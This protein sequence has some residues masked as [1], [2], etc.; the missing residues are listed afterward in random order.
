LWSQH[1][2]HRLLITRL[3]L[4][5]DLHVF[6]GKNVSLFVE[7][8]LCQISA[9]AAVCYALERFTGFERFLKNTLEGLFGFCLFHLNQAENLT[10][11]F[12]VSFVLPFTLAT[13]ALLTIAFFERLRHPKPA[14]I[15]IGLT[16]LLAGLNLAGGLLLGPVAI[17]FA[18]F[19]RLPARCIV[20]VTTLFLVSSSAYLI[21]YKA[22]DPNHTVLDALP[23]GKELFVYLLTYLGASWTKLLP[24]KE[25]LI[26]FLSLVAF[27]YLVM[28]AVR[29]RSRTTSFE[30]FC[31]AECSLLIATAL[32]TGLGRLQ[33][34]VG[35]AYAGRY[36]TPAMLYWASLCAL[37]LIAVWRL[38]PSHFAQMQALVVLIL[39]WSAFTFVPLW[40]TTVRHADLLSSACYTVMHGNQD[41]RAAKLLYGSRQDV[42]P[43]A[44]YLRHLWH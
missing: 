15:A 30:W 2:E 44:A 16:P 28:Q 1:N 14:S 20:T 11:A 25:R 9:W 12:Q 31:A 6:G 7:T 36:Q 38:R 43:G 41:E 32:L 21:G 3:L 40:R 35:Q 24:H 8:Y 29:H 19:K 37:L 22:S 33:M 27:A 23:H 13:V 26:C 18:L 10:W 39:L 4:L 42:A 34:G 5:L 17:G